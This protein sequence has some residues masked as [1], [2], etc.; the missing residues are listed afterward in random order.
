MV[1]GGESVMLSSFNLAKI[2]LG[3]VFCAEQLGRMG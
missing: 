3:G 2:F 1:V